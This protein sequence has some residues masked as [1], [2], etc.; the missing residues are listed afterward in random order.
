M[1]YMSRFTELNDKQWLEQKYEK[2]G[3]ST[4]EIAKLVGAKSG[5]S[6]RQ[7]LVKFGFKLRNLRE[8]Q[9][10]G[11]EDFIIDNREVIDGSLLGD[12]SLQIFNKKSIYCAPYITKKNKYLDHVEYFG[13]LVSKETPLNIT[14]EERL[15]NVENPKWRKFHTSYSFRTRSSERLTPYFNR[16]YPENN[17][18]KKV[19]PSDLVVTPTVLL[20]WFLDDGFSSIR[21]RNKEY[22]KLGFVSRKKQ[23]RVEFCSESF[24]ETENLNLVNQIEK[25][26]IGCYLTQSSAG[27]GCRIK[28]NQSETDDFFKLIGPCPVPSLEYK[29]KLVDNI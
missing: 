19:V 9:V 2:D 11:R 17:G 5:N 27:T 3:L 25:L 24:S 13:G 20:H 15:L 1:D 10:Y 29:W 26:G 7:A 16:W 18:F 8:G 23:I 12:C 6:T 21:N 22:E 14:R 4:V 28:I